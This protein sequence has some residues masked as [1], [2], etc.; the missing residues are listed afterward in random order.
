MIRIVLVILCI[1]IARKHAL[2]AAR[3]R[4]VGRVPAA[5]GNAPPQ[6]RVALANLVHACRFM[7]H[8]DEDS[9]GDEEVAIL[10]ISF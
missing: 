8:G 2:A 6:R 9:V 5:A 1:V 7:R 4:R 3:A 10:Y